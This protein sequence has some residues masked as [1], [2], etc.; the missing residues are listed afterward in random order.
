MSESEVTKENW[1]IITVTKTLPLM[2][3]HKSVA[4][5]DPT[6]KCYTTSF[7]MHYNFRSVK[8]HVINLN[9]AIYLKALVA[10]LPKTVCHVS[11]S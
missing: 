9:M 7:A 6:C 3:L 5:L 10:T 11:F 1:S 2:S 4:Q 8:L